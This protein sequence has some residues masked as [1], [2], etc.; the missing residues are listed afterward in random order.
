MRV[1]LVNT[2]AFVIDKEKRAVPAVVEMGNVNRAPE[3]TAELILLIRRSSAVSGVEIV[4]RIER[5]ITQKSPG[6]SMHIVRA[7]L[8]YGIDDGPI[9]PAEFRAISIRLNFEFCEC[10]DRRLDDV[11]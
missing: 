8:D 5:A 2:Q 1:G 9:A 4:A 6:A 10:V 3:S 11:V 7:G